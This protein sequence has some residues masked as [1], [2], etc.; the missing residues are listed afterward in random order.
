MNNI[1]LQLQIGSNNHLGFRM[2]KKCFHKQTVILLQL[3]P[4]SNNHLGFRMLKTLIHK[5]TQSYY[6]ILI[7][8][9]SSS[10]DSLF[11]IFFPDLGEFIQLTITQ[12]IKNTKIPTII[13][14]LLFW[15]PTSLYNF[16]FS[17]LKDNTNSSKFLDFCSTL[18]IS[19]SSW[20]N[21]LSSPGITIVDLLHI[22]GS[23]QIQKSHPSPFKKNPF[24]F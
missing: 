6:N 10:M 14:A 17:D 20:F 12:I 21:F 5:Q 22:S 19:A 13:F 8:H 1:L 3:H 4:G 11:A 18:P 15:I 2:L 16:A 23:T 7:S 24:L 9:N